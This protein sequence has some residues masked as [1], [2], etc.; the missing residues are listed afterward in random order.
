VPENQRKFKSLPISSKPFEIQLRK[1]AV[2]SLSI[3]KDLPVWEVN[4]L[5]SIA[6]QFQVDTQGKNL[7][8]QYKEYK[9]QPANLVQTV[10]KTMEDTVN[11]ECETMYDVSPLPEWVMQYK[12]E[13]VP[14]PNLKSNGEIIDIV[15]TKNFSNCD[16]RVGY[17]FGLNGITD[18]KEANENKLGTF[19]AVSIFIL[20]IY[21]L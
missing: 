13:L 21:K 3:S 14:M 12:P 20:I 8:K 17:H 10:F 16:Q 18:W 11:G 5:K 7:M 1:G 15:K 6:S 19:L 4:I 9:N 2:S